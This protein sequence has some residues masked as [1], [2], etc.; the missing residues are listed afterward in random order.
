VNVGAD[1]LSAVKRLSATRRDEVLDLVCDKNRPVDVMML[2]G[3]RPV[4][5]TSRFL[6]VI[7]KS[8]DMRLVIELPT[9]G[10]RSMTCEEGAELE[11][12]FHVEGE[13]YAFA[14]R[15]LGRCIFPLNREQKVAAL[16][17]RYPAE[18]ES[19]QRRAHY[20]VPLGIA[21]QVSVAFL[22]HY[23]TDMPADACRIYAGVISDISAGGVAVV[24]RQRLAS[25]M[26]T[27][28]RVSM[29]FQVPGEPE[30]LALKGIIRN[31]RLTDEGTTRLLG[32]EY[33]LSDHDIQTK[34][35]INLIQRFVVKRQRE[36]LKKLRML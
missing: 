11:G 21:S 19:R 33:V 30:H 16:V 24:C 5:Y 31:D 23:G 4:G 2:S 3:D 34:Q 6:M 13:R 15:V 1:M 28:A 36:I 14:T 25:S 8:D 29:S 26:A 27:G 9:E 22:E 32:I 7:E 12:V 20:R 35:Y 18:V 10:G 17:V